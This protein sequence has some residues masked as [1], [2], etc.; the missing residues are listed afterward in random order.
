M[1]PSAPARPPGVD[2]I[3]AG[4]PM[5]SPD[6]FEGVRAIAEAVGNMPAEVGHCYYCH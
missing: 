1:R 5:A 4:F 6:D 2:V 3:E